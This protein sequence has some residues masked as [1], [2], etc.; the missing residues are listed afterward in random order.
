[1]TPGTRQLVLLIYS[2]ELV[3]RGDFGRRGVN[4]RNIIQRHLQ[5][6]ANFVDLTRDYLVEESQENGL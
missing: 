6:S 3:R 4:V 1:M 2:R 5:R